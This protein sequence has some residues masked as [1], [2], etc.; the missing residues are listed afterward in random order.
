MEID[1]KT[2]ALQELF[3]DYEN[4]ERC[5]LSSPE[6]CRRS[7]I[8]FG[9]GDPDAKVMIIGDY[10]RMDDEAEAEPFSSRSNSG[11]LLDRILASLGATRDQ[12]WIDQMV[13]CVPHKN[14]HEERPPNKDEVA[15]CK[16]RLYEVIKIVD[17]R[18][19]L[20]LGATALRLAKKWADPWDKDVA[21]FREGISS[22]A[23]APVKPRLVVEV[24]GVMGP[25][26]YEA[27]ATFH[28]K[29]ILRLTSQEFN[30]QGGPNDHMYQSWENAFKYVQMGE[31]LYTGRVPYRD[32]E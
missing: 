14:A 32:M 26:R 19:I 18:I 22:V 15:A 24:P 9:Q 16:D 10:P 13:M 1:Q 12:V 3:W 23:T 4:C 2:Q 21:P 17:P 6:G 8:V 5:P 27:R 11:I 25:I 28:P 7:N 29:F 20:L 31:Y 30:R